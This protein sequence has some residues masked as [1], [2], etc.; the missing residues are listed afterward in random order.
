MRFAFEV[1]VEHEPVLHGLA[2]EVVM[3]VYDNGFLMERLTIT[4]KGSRN[5]YGEQK[6]RSCFR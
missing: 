4:A 3:G 5:S 2:D 1:L 6:K